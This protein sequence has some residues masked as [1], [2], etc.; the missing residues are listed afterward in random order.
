MRTIDPEKHTAR[1]DAMSN[2]PSTPCPRIA[3]IDALRG[4][5]LFGILVVNIGAFATPWF[6]LGLSDP[7]FHGSVDRATHFLVALLFETKF[8]LLFSFLFGYSITLQMQAAARANAPFVPRMLRRQAGLWLIGALH[9]VFL[10]HGDILTTYAVLGMVLLVLHRC[11][12]RQALSLALMLVTVCVGFWG[13]MAWLQSLQPAHAAA[14]QAVS[15]A[16]KAASALA[17]YRATPAT[18]I[19]QHVRELNDIW[20]VL[21]L[22]QAPCALA[23][24]LCGMAAGKR[25]MLL[26]ASDYLPL[27]RRLLWAGALAGLPCAAFYAWTSVYADSQAWQV[28]GLAVG[29]ASAPL[30]AGAYLALALAL[31]G[32]LRNGTL[33]ALL[34]EAGRMA[35]SN[36]LLQSAVCAWLF[37]AY[38]LRL[39]GSVS[40]LGALALA[41]I[42]FS[43][44]LPLSHWWLRGHAYGPVEWL[45]RALTN[46]AWPRWRRASA[47]TG[48]L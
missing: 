9:A 4:C 6:G 18:V 7:A 39:M 45:L 29:L 32:R 27:R 44:Q 20:I 3:D 17:A 43:L 36:Y 15:M 11:G 37:L 21:L 23:M 48:Y 12:E 30:L 46:A 1:R 22:V 5:A 42:I 38:G 31:F 25:E 34:A 35:L 47:S 14:Q 40:P 16:Q 26:H 41:V 13:A 28:A 24:F 33:F 8:Y 19:A 2:V 10:F